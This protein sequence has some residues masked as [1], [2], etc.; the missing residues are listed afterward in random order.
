[1]KTRPLDVVGAL[2][3]TPT[4][5]PDRRGLFVSPFQGDAFTAAL[6][7]PMTVAQTNHN[8]SANGVVRGIHFTRYPPGQAKLV[9]CARGRALDFV[10]DLRVGSPTFGRWDGVEIDDQSFRSV[11]F[12]PGCGH[13]FIALEEDT[14]MS[15]LVSTGYAPELELSI[16][17]LDRDIAL[18][19]PSG[20]DFVLSDRDL[21]APS[22]AE[23][24]SAGLLPQYADLA[25]C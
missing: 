13:A 21:A 6:G 12:P 19:W 16:H 8:R 20:F 24:G 4:V 18:P 2:E 14:V 3:F 23:A 15:Y 1:M 17:P 5:F 11:Y 22:L 9:H 10:V 25:G 7:H